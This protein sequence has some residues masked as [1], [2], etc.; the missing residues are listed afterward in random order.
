MST[1][2]PAPPAVACTLTAATLRFADRDGSGDR[3]AE[4]VLAFSPEQRTA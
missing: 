3:L 4:L 2:T 1:S